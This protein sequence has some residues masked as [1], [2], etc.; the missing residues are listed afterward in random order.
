MKLTQAGSPSHSVMLLSLV[1]LPASGSDSPITSSVFSDNVDPMFLMSSNSPGAICWPYRAE[2]GY[3][4]I[5]I[6]FRPVKKF[7]SLILSI[8]S[9]HN[10]KNRNT[11]WVCRISTSHSTHNG[12]FWGRVFPA[13]HVT[14]VLTNQTC[15]VQDKQ[16]KPK[17]LNLTK[18]N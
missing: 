18:P 1:S 16:K 3:R 6:A 10:N 15:N 13:N 11:E 17:Q 9:C 2:C 7:S 14:I 5:P 8:C 4:S 12:S